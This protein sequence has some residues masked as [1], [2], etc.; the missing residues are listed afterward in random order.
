MMIWRF[1]AS[2]KTPS[3]R[4]HC[5][6][7]LNLQQNNRFDGQVQYTVSSWCF[8]HLEQLSY[9]DE[10]IGRRRRDNSQLGA[11][12]RLHVRM[13]KFFELR[14]LHSFHVVLF[15]LAL[16][17]RFELHDGGMKLLDETVVG[18]NFMNCLGAFMRINQT[19]LSLANSCVRPTSSLHV[20]R[21]F[22]YLH[23][24][25]ASVLGRECRSLS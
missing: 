2:E 13:S 22:W 6:N 4:Q 14:F 16:V 10:F 20:L 5:I 25:F 11:G 17:L 1:Q 23:M 24:H 12:V 9:H 7:T 19:L 18:L 8:V 15:L 3:S 21:C